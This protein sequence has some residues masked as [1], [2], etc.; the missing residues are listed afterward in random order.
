MGV[1]ATQP[2]A[3]THHRVPEAVGRHHELA[4]QV[5]AQRGLI[6]HV[7]G[8][9]VLA[10]RARRDETVECGVLD[11]ARQIVLHD[12]GLV[13]P[14]DLVARLLEQRRAAVGL[15]ALHQGAQHLVVKLDEGLLDLVDDG[16]LIVALVAD[17]GTAVR[18]AWQIMAVKHH[19][20]PCVAPAGRAVGVGLLVQIGLVVGAVAV[21]AIKV[22]TRRAD[23][24]GI[25]GGLGRVFQILVEVER[26]CGVER[27]IMVDELAQIGVAGRH[28]QTLLGVG[29][30]RRWIDRA[31]HRHGQRGQHLVVV[32]WRLAQIQQVS[33]LGKVETLA[34]S[35]VGA[36]EGIAGGCAHVVAFRSGL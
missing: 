10:G 34:M 4:R 22:K 24:A 13:G 14:A 26:G 27:Q 6:Q 29:A 3:G 31:Q 25:V 35:S 36:G 32:A 1:R 5:G 21:D 20:G 23:V 12:D 28:E 33:E 2:V 19:R 9:L 15:A 16:V 7:G 8:V 18:G 11:D 17:Q 30:V